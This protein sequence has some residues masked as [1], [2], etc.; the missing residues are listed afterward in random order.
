MQFRFTPTYSDIIDGNPENL[1]DLLSKIPT[2]ALLFTIAGISSLIDANYTQIEIIRFFFRRDFQKLDDLVPKFR[3]YYSSNLSQLS[4]FHKFY[5][6]RLAIAGLSNPNN[7]NEDT[8]PE[9]DWFIFK[10]YIIVVSEYLIKQKEIY[11]TESSKEV[12]AFNKLTWPVMAE[13]YQFREQE[14]D[15]FDMIRTITLVDELVKR[16]FD[17]E[18]KKFSQ[19]IGCPVLD[20]IYNIDGIIHHQ[21]ELEINGWKIPSFFIKVDKKNAFLFNGLAL[22]IQKITEEMNFDDNYLALKKFP[23]LKHGDDVFVVLNRDF[24]ASKIYNGFVFDFYQRSGIKSVYKDFAEFKSFIG[25]EISEERLFKSM[26][27]S[28]YTKKHNVLI[29]SKD[30]SHPDC[31]LRIG[32]RIFLIEFKDYLMASKTMT[33]YNA[34]I[35]Q[36]KLNLQFIENDKK[37]PK[38]VSQLA[39]QIRFLENS[40]YDFDI[41]TNSKIRRSKIEIYPIIVFTDLQ[42]TMPGINSYLVKCFWTKYEDKSLFKEVNDPIMISMSFLMKYMQYIERNRLDRI[43]KSYFRRIN[44]IKKDLKTRPTPSKWVEANLSLDGIGPKLDS[45]KKASKFLIQEYIEKLNLSNVK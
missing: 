5:L 21:E 43:I 9:E 39:N 13:Q 15:Y 20:Y 17:N 27:K 25:K 31:Y 2:K 12:E 35:F 45:N 41:Y 22:D 44:T 16:G 10:A 3:K 30:D 34:E 19:L 4:I 32:H 29:F 8:T 37:N 1:K 38:G 24:L 42:Y 36:K 40:E 11:E 28:I 6:N 18:L 14:Y 33:S 7:R 23:L 26:L